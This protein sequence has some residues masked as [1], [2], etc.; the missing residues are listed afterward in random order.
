MGEDEGQRP[1]DV[2]RCLEQDFPL[3]QRLADQPELI[4]FEIAQPAVNQLGGGRTG[5]LGEIV[6]FDQ[7]HLQLADRGVA[8]DGGAVDA[9]A[10]RSEER[11]VGKE[12]VSTCS[13]RWSPYTSKKKNKKLLVY[14]HT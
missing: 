12:C 1:D 14:E 8:G 4:I 3:L 6:L 7:E 13:S 5:M 9:A 11:R 10:Y 2:R